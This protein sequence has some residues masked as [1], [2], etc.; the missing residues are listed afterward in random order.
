MNIIKHKDIPKL[1]LMQHSVPSPYFKIIMLL[2]VL[3]LSIFYITL[4]NTVLQK[5]ISTDAETLTFPSFSASAHYQQ[6]HNSK[7]PTFYTKN[8]LLGQYATANGV[9][10][11]YLNELVNI[12]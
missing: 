12:F 7:L 5:Y 11:H 10:T 3:S 9:K 8:D 6:I 4:F 2:S 1:M